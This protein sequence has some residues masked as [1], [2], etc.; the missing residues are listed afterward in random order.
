LE[1]L[2]FRS[3]YQEYGLEYTIFRFFNTYGPNQ[4]EDF[5]IPRFLKLALS[6]KPINIYGEGSQTRTFCYV[7]DNI[8]TCIKVM[9][10][11]KSINDVL[12]VGS[13]IEISVLNLAKFIIKFTNS[14]SKLIHVPALKEG[15]MTR[16]CPN[17]AKM[18]SILNRDLMTLE[19]GLAKMIAYY[20]S[21]Y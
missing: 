8:E 14:K 2:F 21:R 4:S 20:E 5:V 15:D 13:A 18:K 17:N 19:E 9:I 12:N 1:K 3:Y 6:N 16:R 11:S 10:S 7:D